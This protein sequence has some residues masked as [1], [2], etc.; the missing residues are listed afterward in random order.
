MDHRQP[1][2]F[3]VAVVGDPA[4]M[5]AAHLA[6]LVETLVARH[7]DTRR[8]C[9]VS[10]G[11][12]GPELRWCHDRGWTLFYEPASDGVVKQDYAIAAI[13]H[14]LIVLGDPKP[15]T[16]LLSLCA[17][18]RIPTRI[19]RTAPKLPAPRRDLPL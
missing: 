19:Y 9:L 17:E 18:A 13:A 14:A 8:I 2:A 5:D 11:G 4:V 6:R 12:E 16:R 10:A 7:R 1:Y 3:I 15:W